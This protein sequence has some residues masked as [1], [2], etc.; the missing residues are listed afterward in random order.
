MPDGTAVRI[1]RVASVR[2]RLTVIWIAGSGL[3]AGAVVV[4]YLIAGVVDRAVHGHLIMAGLAALLILVELTRALQTLTLAWFAWMAADPVPMTPEPDQ[5]VALLTTVVPDREPLEMLRRTLEAM[6]RVRHYGPVDVWVLDEGA[7][8]RVRSMA[9]GLGVR[10]FTRHGRPDRNT[11]SGPFRARS[12]AG[13]HNAWRVE[14]EHDYDLVGQMD[15]DHVAL[16]TFLERT[17][18]YFKDPDVGFVVAPQVYGNI[19]R[20]RVAHAAAAQAYLFAG[21]VQRGGNGIRAPLLIGT[22]H[23]YRVRAWS[24]IGGYQ[25]SLIEDHL[26]GL[27]LS[28]TTN[29]LTGR[30]WYGVYAPDILAVGEGPASWRDFFA[31]QRRWSYGVAEVLTRH[32][33]RLLPRLSARQRLAYILLESFYPS[34]ALGWSLGHVITAGFL[35]STATP[36]LLTG[37]AALCWTYAMAAAIGLVVWLRR[38]NIADHE[39]RDRGLRG[40]LATVVCGPVYAAAV[41][42]AVVRR[43]LAYQVTGKG[44]LAAVDGVGSFAVHLVWGCLL[45]GVATTALLTREVGLVVWGWAA[46]LLALSLLPPAAVVVARWRRRT[47]GA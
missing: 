19:A 44:P 42:R 3:A 39:R 24:Q 11:L 34:C 16:P 4:A 10:Y 45:A 31:Q 25:D 14:H 15:P 35:I 32:S 26:T 13:N 36:T 20:S 22:N 28:G 6:R 18:G 9:A 21:V 2:E 7:D 33:P 37:A 43:S 1:E 17:L 47:G 30:R 23:V 12:K 40:M 8:P 46:F 5:R 29:L 41:A 38:F 27:T